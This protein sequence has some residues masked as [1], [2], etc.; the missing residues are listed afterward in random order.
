M[1][2]ENIKR[3]LEIK[4]LSLSENIKESQN[5]SVAMEI[6]M[7]TEKKYITKSDHKEQVMK[8]LSWKIKPF[9][10]YREVY[11]I[12]QLFHLTS[13]EAEAILKEL[14]DESKTFPL[15]VEGSREMHYMLKAD[16]QLQLLMD[17]KKS[18]K[19]PAFLTSPRIYPSGEWRKDEWVIAIQNFVLDKDLKNKIPSYAYFEPLR[20]VLMYMPT[21]PEWM[22]F[23]QK[24]P[25]DIINTLFR[26]YKYVWTSG[27]LHPDMNAMI[28]GYLENERIEPER[29]EKYKL[30]F[31]FYQ[32]ILPGRINEI[33]LK[34]R[35]DVPEGMYY[36]AIYHQ[37]KGDISEALELY[38]QSLKD[39]NSKTFDN[40]LINFFYTIT[41]INDFTIESKKTLKNLF[42]RDYL[43]PD[44]MPSQLLAL[45][46]LN[47][48]MDSAIDHILYNYG[49]LPPLTKV[50]IMLVVRHFRLNK[51][52]KIKISDEEMQQFIDADHLK[53][54]QLECSQD[55][56][57]YSAKAGR[58]KQEIGYS[59]LLPP[60]KK[61]DEWERVLALLLDKS[62][63]LPQKIKENKKK[64]EL[65]TRIV[66][67][68]DQYNSINP[69]L[70]KSKDGITWSKGRIISLTTFQQGMPE[71]NETDHALTMCIK[72]L[73]NDWAEKNRMRLCGPKPIMQLAG[74]PLVFS[75]EHPEK[76][77]TIQKEE[78]QIIVTKT[79]NGFKVESNV[80]TD[81]IEG[82][83]MVKR[84]NETLIKVIEIRS[85]QRDIILTLN[86]VSNYPPQA[87]ERLTE[88]LRELSE[89]FVVHFECLE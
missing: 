6:K 67:R 14:E 15:I 8:Y 78:P 88:V 73:S 61:V 84:V 27:L 77:I 28:N 45:Y 29:R 37:Y 33:P 57:P 26:E 44:M 85:F 41:L 39:M 36:H 79:T 35:D 31:A 22:P 4:Y 2:L 48:K 70:Q 12:S 20:Y 23:F 30:E 83:Y 16:I 40:A 21:F 47:E 66:Y 75:D 32:Y 52:I 65:K 24:I 25:T 87:E 10:P 82:V 71:M 69:Y 46:A 59:P 55:F 43:S 17:I 51:K 76:T 34:I 5:R 63:E 86:R 58:L 72:T 19:K 42:M 50:L 68:I 80:D 64:A 54:L 49:N 56:A 60:Y 7:D 9:I 38:T 53:L 62:K 3:I 74:Y 11:E 81:R 13:V 89:N 18:H 1:N